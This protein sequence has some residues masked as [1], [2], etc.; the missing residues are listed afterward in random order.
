MGHLSPAKRLAIF[1]MTCLVAGFILMGIFGPAHAAGLGSSN[2]PASSPNVSAATGTLPVANGG[3]G[4][5][6]AP[7][8]QGTRITTIQVVTT[9][10]YTKV[11]LNSIAF[12]TATYWDGTNFWYKPLVAGTYLV[13]V[14]V[15]SGGT[16]VTE[17]D[18][19]ASKNGLTGGSGIQIAHAFSPASATSGDSGGRCGMVA[20]NGST[21][22]IELDGYVAGT[23]TTVVGSNVGT[24][25]SIL[26]VS[27]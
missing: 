18:A 26:W 24:T 23:G 8:M 14:G 6:S 22:T 3:T 12:D 27:P 4:T 19:V 17:T 9:S 25:M 1:L 15:V 20:M 16:T 11:Q 5:T 21:D 2:P 13:C 10:T 7:K